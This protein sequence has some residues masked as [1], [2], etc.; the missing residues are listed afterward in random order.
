MA[1]VLAAHI[2]VE[3]ATIYLLGESGR[4]Q[5]ELTVDERAGAHEAQHMAQSDYPILGLVSI[6]SAT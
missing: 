5:Q 2:E 1:I 3:G 6:S 4:L